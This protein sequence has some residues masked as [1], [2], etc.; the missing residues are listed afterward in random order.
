MT[1]SA[2]QGDGPAPG[3]RSQRR[4][5]AGPNVRRAACFAPKSPERIGAAGSAGR[6][7]LATWAAA[8]QGAATE[9][10]VNGSVP[11]APPR[12]RLEAGPIGP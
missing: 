7:E 6:H 5:C 10:S 8:P 9:V 11:L 1:P 4:A 2:R 3:R 12:E